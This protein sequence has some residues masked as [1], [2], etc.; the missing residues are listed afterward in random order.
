MTDKQLD[1]NSLEP[2]VPEIHEMSAEQ[3]EEVA[4]GWNTKRKVYYVFCSE[5]RS[6][7]A[8]YNDEQL[9]QVV[10]N[11]CRNCGAPRTSPYIN[12]NLCPPPVEY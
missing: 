6:A 11:P 10:T 2:E 7:Y 5:C 1:N 12:P 3:L 8:C 4:G 9:R